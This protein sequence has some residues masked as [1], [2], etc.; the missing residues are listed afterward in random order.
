[1]AAGRPRKNVFSRG[2]AGEWGFMLK[3]EKYWV[4]KIFAI[5]YDEPTMYC[6]SR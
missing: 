1:M 4:D 5:I 2:G 3:K 6:Q